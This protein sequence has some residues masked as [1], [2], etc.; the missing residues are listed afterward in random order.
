[1]DNALS[2]CPSRVSVPDGVGVCCR[3]FCGND[4]DIVGLGRRGDGECVVHG[5]SVVELGSD[6]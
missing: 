6:Y 4:G 1:M 5:G 2:F 3:D